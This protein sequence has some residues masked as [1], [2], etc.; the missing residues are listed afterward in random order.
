[1]RRTTRPPT[2]PK[3]YDNS[4][5][6]PRPHSVAAKTIKAPGFPAIELGG[7]I[8]RGS[9]GAVY[10]A[11]EQGNSSAQ[12][13]VKCQSPGQGR[14]ESHYHWLVQ[15]KIPE[16]GGQICALLATAEC[17]NT[18][19]SIQP[20]YFQ[21]L[22]QFIGENPQPLRLIRK[23]LQELAFAFAK[24]HQIHLIHL[25]V[26]PQNIMVNERGTEP[27]IGDFGSADF[28][29]EVVPSFEQVTRYYR[30][31]ELILH[32][33]RTPAVDIWAIGATAAEMYL[34]RPIF[35]GRNEHE[36]LEL[37]EMRLGEFPEKFICQSAL[38]CGYYNDDGSVINSERVED[39]IYGR[40]SL[41]LL[42]LNRNCYGENEKELGDFL[43]L[44]LQMLVFDPASRITAS[45]ILNHAFL[46]RGSGG[47]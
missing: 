42:I 4:R 7:F 43:D 29:R 44:V 21:N 1:M 17:G 14:I 23:V 32:V 46:T 25:D 28:E 47:S 31:P 5:P 19:F 33:S 3:G 10:R 35:A 8:A 27:R 38:K 26:K 22:H 34:G 41:E 39:P 20:L 11:A 9:C 18:H 24:I 36:M 12:Y 15:R 40:N 45:E 13:A 6:S 30:A 37:M 16:I 2:P